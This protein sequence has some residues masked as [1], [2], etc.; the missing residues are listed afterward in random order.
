MLIVPST[1]MPYATGKII[2][3]PL[4]LHLSINPFVCIYTLGSIL[5]AVFLIS[6]FG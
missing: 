1:K 5:V 4:R 2:L 3:F 6:M